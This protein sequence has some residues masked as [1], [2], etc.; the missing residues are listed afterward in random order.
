MADDAD[1]SARPVGA[2]RV[3]PL[4]RGREKTRHALAGLLRALADD[5]ERG[6]LIGVAVVTELPGG[7]VG[8]VYNFNDFHRML[9]G[10]E[11]LKARLLAR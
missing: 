3:I 8:T 1:P 4:T 7:C 11:S 6:D 10:I 5:A 9:G 2:L